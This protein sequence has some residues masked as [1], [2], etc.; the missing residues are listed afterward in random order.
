[1]DSTSLAWW[2]KYR[3]E[4]DPDG[5]EIKQGISGIVLIKYL[6]PVDINTV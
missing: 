2:M 3:V 6:K 1:M 5:V 4:M